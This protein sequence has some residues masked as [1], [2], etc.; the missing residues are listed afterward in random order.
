M[1]SLSRAVGISCSTHAVIGALL[2]LSMAK[3]IMR[4]PEQKKQ[5]AY[6]APVQ[7]RAQ[8]PRPALPAPLPPVSTPVVAPQAAA[9]LPTP[10]PAPQP[11]VQL[12]QSIQAEHTP[13]VPTKHKTR[14]TAAKHIAAPVPPSQHIQQEP[15]RSHVHSWRRMAKAHTI[16]QRVQASPQQDSPLSYAYASHTKIPAHQ[17]SEALLAQEA[18]ARF[19]AQYEED[20][21]RRYTYEVGHAILCAY[22]AHPVV[23]APCDV[24]NDLCLVVTIDNTGQLVS[25]ETTR[26]YTLA[27]QERLSQRLITSTQKAAP[28]RAPP[29]NGLPSVQL[30]YYLKSEISIDRSST[31]P[32]PLTLTISP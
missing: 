21:H 27:A 2:L 6:Q 12:T 15:K 31:Y 5:P 28:F 32:V 3:Q 10:T 16:N 8:K 4:P 26:P 17:K 14:Q 1:S 24:P 13:R 19:N 29:A 7:M 22:N 20:R 9:A 30:G 25:V 23:I 11:T 18:T